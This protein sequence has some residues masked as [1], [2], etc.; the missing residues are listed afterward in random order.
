MSSC[1]ATMLHGSVCVSCMSPCLATSDASCGSCRLGSVCVACTKTTI[2]AM[3]PS[4]E[5]VRQ[6]FYTKVLQLFE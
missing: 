3:S 4:A 1:P 2:L 5:Q 6:R